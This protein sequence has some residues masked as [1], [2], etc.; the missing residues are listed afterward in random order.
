[1]KCGYLLP[2][3]PL[4]AEPPGHLLGRLRPYQVRRVRDVSV[5][6]QRRTSCCKT[7][8]NA[9]YPVM[10]RGDPSGQ[11]SALFELYFESFVAASRTLL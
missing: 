9:Q 1:M 2:L 8:P 7:D 3:L 5:G 6:L 11:Q 10:L 4:P